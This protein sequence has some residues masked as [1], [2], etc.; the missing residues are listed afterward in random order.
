MNYNKESKMSRTKAD[1][2]AE[3]VSILCGDHISNAPI[4]IIDDYLMRE[5]MENRREQGLEIPEEFTKET[6]TDVERICF[7][8]DKRF[9]QCEDD[10]YQAQK[11]REQA[12]LEKEIDEDYVFNNSE[13]GLIEKTI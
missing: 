5:L 4:Q 12:H 9:S 1:R 6:R 3:I 7:A 11:D 10:R 8:T 2:D 13:F